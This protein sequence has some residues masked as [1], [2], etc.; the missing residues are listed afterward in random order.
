MYTR[1]YAAPWMYEAA[2]GLKAV[3]DEVGDFAGEPGRGLGG[4]PPGR[5]LPHHRRAQG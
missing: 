2:Q 4:P 3:A 5:H 1:R